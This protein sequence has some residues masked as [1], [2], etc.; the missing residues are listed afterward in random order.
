MAAAILTIVL[1]FIVGGSAWLLLGPRLPLAAAA[2]QN[3]L[4]NLIAYVVGV[5][6]VAFLIV[7]FLLEVL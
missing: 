5:L 2:E 3:Q 6:P 1:A 4:L 7:F